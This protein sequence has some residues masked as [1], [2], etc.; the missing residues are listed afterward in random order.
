MPMPSFLSFERKNAAGDNVLSVD[1]DF[2]TGRYL[3]LRQGVGHGVTIDL[4]H[5][6]W[7]LEVLSDIAVTQEDERWIT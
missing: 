5:V 7:L 4:E 6:P 2:T 3:L 1:A